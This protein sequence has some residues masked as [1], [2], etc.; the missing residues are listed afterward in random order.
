MIL[1]IRTK[2]FIALF[3]ACLIAILGMAFVIQQNFTSSFL[4]YVNEQENRSL[5][6]LESQ[7]TDY[8]QRN[9]NWHDLVDDPRQWSGLLHSAVRS[10]LF[11]VDGDDGRRRPRAEFEDD[12]RP[13]P[14]IQMR[15]DRYI[16]RVVLLDAQKQL[17]R[18]NP[19]LELPSNLRPLVVDKQTVGYLG[20]HPRQRLTEKVDL[21]FADRLQTTLWIVGLVMLLVA[22]TISYYLARQLGRPIQVLRQ[23]TR[24]LANGNYALRMPL[25][26]HDEL[27]QLTQD[28]NQ[29]AERLQQNEQSRKQWIADI[30][31]ELRTPL[32]ILRG[33]I[34][35]IQDGINQADAQTLAS[36]HQEAVHL[37][38]LV[39]DLYDLSMSDNGAL[40]YQKSRVN[41]TQVL[42]ET[43]TVYHTVLQEKQLYLDSQAIKP[44]AVWLQADSQRLHQLFKNLLENSLRY[45]D[46]PGTL[47][48]ATYIS[49]TYIEIVFQD[50]APGVPPEALS[51]LFDRLYRVEGSRNRATGGAG[52]GLSICKNIVEAHQGSISAA[53]ASLGGLAI[54]IKLP[55]DK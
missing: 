42:Q 45:T 28:F 18:G 37:E 12:K 22:G 41:L 8:Y 15:I 2:L 4:A 39:N 47:Q 17:I 53:P 44:Q 52:I 32:A 20:L 46:K 6:Q 11:P 1:S 51:R 13:P 3:A 21:E 25:I 27:T 5:A 30:A 7:L 50:S 40:S 43:L 19:R 54:R 55:I 31:H 36:L 49:P 10:S 33:E 14:H 38:R 35:A 24:Q 48:V 16:G 23:G 34:E 9:G 26:G 29:L